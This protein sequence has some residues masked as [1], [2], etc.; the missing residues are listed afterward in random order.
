MSKL[1]TQE[2]NPNGLHGRYIVSKTSG[3]PVDERAEYFILRLDEFGSD[4]N[5]IIACRRAAVTYAKEI[6]PHIPQLAE[7]LVKRYKLDL[8]DDYDC[9]G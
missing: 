1:P 2:E 4:P 7:D 6:Y 8:N 3:E 5:H 9:F